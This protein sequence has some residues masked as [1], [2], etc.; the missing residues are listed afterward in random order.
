MCLYNSA[1][2]AA[3]A[4]KHSG[5]GVC[6]MHV[7]NSC[8]HVAWLCCEKAAKLDALGVLRRH[9]MTTS[10]SSS[11]SSRHGSVECCVAYV[12]HYCRMVVLVRGD[13]RQRIGIVVG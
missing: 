2:A 10:S 5:L 3:A 8:D 13:K 4:V 11:S 7:C 12:Y 6:N 9:S 1:A